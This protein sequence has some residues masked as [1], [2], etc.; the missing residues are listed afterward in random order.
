MKIGYKDLI[1]E[2]KSR[3]EALRPDY[4]AAIV[5]LGKGTDGPMAKAVIREA[6]E[7]KDEIFKMEMREY[8]VKAKNIKDFCDRYHARSAYHDRGADYMACDLQ[9]HEEEFEE[10]GFAMI[11]QGSS[12]T[13][14]IVTFFG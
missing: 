5:A 9:S 14:D 3:L 10:Y 13:G 12:T 4:K 1:A 11:P 6:G 7:L 8:E 2:Y